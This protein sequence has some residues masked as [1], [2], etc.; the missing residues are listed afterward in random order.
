MLKNFAPLQVTTRYLLSEPAEVATPREKERDLQEEIERRNPTETD[1]NAREQSLEP[2]DKGMI[3]PLEEEEKSS[4]KK[5]L[6]PTDVV[7]PVE[8]SEKKKDSKT[9]IDNTGMVIPT[10]E[11]EK[12]KEPKE[13]H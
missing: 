13:Y 6:N 2:V 3:I 5:V 9:P 10:E 4:E 12:K 11:T 8:D 7:I 1:L